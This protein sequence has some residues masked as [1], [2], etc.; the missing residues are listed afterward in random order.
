MGT[1]PIFESD[2][3]C[4]TEWLPQKN[5]KQKSKVGESQ[6]RISSTMS[7]N[8]FLKKTKATDQKLEPIRL[9]LLS[10]NLTNFSRNTKCSK[11][12]LLR[13]NVGW[14]VGFPKFRK[15]WTR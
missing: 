12:D 15:L 6:L 10:E 11:L 2:F 7:E 14:K 3:D 1:H 5:S 4:L 13:R 9:K 8:I